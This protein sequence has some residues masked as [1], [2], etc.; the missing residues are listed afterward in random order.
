M[1][2]TLNTWLLH[3]FFH[4]FIHWLHRSFPA[5][6][7]VEKFPGLSPLMEG[8]NSNRTNWHLLSEGKGD[9]L[10]TQQ[11]AIKLKEFPHQNAGIY[12]CGVLREQCHGFLFLGSLNKVKFFGV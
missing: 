3:V 5:Q 7:L 9:H 4:N 1:S 8:S 11:L 12:A 10:I 2:I 6:A